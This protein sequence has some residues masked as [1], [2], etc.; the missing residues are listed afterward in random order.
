MVHNKK[1]I[2]NLAGIGF[3]KSLFYQLISLI[4]DGAI[5]FMVLPII[6]LITDQVCLPIIISYCKF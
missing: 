5:V 4:R 2:I 1:D 6:T 3:D